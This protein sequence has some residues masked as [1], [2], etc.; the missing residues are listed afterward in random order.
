M[1]ENTLSRSLSPDILSYEYPC[2]APTNEI[3]CTQNFP[4]LV[5]LFDLLKQHSDWLNFRHYQNKDYLICR[6]TKRDADQALILIFKIN[7]FSALFIFQGFSL[8]TDELY[9][10]GTDTGF[11]IDY[12]FLHTCDPSVF[13][14]FPT[15]K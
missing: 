5:C 2:W 11:R 13:F 7:K 1:P 12:S 4:A 9:Q 3:D 6:L 10:G 14:K 8:V 15:A